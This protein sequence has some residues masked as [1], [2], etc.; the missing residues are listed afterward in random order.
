ACSGATTLNVHGAGQW[1]EPKQLDAV[2]AD[3]EVV[4]VS[5][6]GNDTRLFE[7]IHSCS[8][9][10]DAQACE[11]ALTEVDNNIRA[12]WFRDRIRDAYVAIR[13]KTPNAQVIVVGYPHILGTVG[14]PHCGWLAH[15]ITPLEVSLVDSIGVGIN[16]VLQQEAAQANFTYVSTVEAFRGHKVCDEQPF[17]YSVVSANPGHS[18]HPNGAGVNAIYTLLK[19]ELA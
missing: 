6:G 13:A 10:V 3:T 17:A 18:Y 14:E 12:P 5:A 16:S 15:D 7:A 19:A 4:V 11:A 8:T 1:N 2:A 9:T